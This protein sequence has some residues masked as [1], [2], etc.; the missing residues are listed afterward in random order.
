MIRGRYLIVQMI[1][2]GARSDVYLAVDQGDGIAVALKRTFIG[3]LEQAATSSFERE[4]IALTRL[5]HPVLPKV[6]DH[7]TEMDH[8]FLVMEHIS[9]ENLENRLESAGKPFPV[10]WVMFWA[11]QLLDALNYLHS[12]VPPIYHG[13]VNPGNLKLTAENHVVLL[14]LGL[15]AGLNRSTDFNLAASSKPAILSQHFPSPEQLRGTRMEAPGDLYS[16]AA[17][18][19]QLV[20]NALPADPMQR[21]DEISVSGT[22]PLRL[23]SDLNI[24]VSNAVASVIVKGM[25][26]RP[27]ERFATAVDMQRELRKAF[28]LVETPKGAETAVMPKGMAGKLRSEPEVKTP[29]V[30]ADDPMDATINMGAPTRSDVTKQSDVRTEVFQVVQTSPQVDSPP[31]PT[32]FQTP[33]VEPAIPPAPIASAPVIDQYPSQVT[34]IAAVKKPSSKTGIFVGVAVGLL[35]LAVVAAGGGFFLYKTYFD[36]PI[37]EATPTPAPTG[38]PTP[39]E[40]IAA[41]DPNRSAADPTPELIEPSEGKVNSDTRTVATPAPQTYSTPPPRVTVRTTPAGPAKPPPPRATPKLPP[42]RDDRTVILQ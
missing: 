21:V 23:P 11:D 7:F 1:G 35:L 17:S 8:H 19:F 14:D 12:H 28:N 15:S 38:V 6:K 40:V 2:Q 4:A 42:A 9:G 3:D 33:H 34:Q 41:Q 18:L 27:N 37:A 39:S 16:L 36:K 20:T 24:E 13:D 5:T 10:S 32:P 29:P 22:D 31:P 25:A 30:S 26:L